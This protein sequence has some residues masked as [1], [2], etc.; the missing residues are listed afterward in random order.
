MPVFGG[1]RVAFREALELHDQED[2]EK[3]I[4]EC[5]FNMKDEDSK[6]VEKKLEAMMSFIAEL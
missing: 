3:A 6:K 2:L 4:L 1:C 5:Y